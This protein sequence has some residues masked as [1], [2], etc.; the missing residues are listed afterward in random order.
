MSGPTWQHV[1]PHNL[2][3]CP[4]VER[5]DGRDYARV[6]CPDCHG[7]GVVLKHPIP[8]EHP[9]LAKGA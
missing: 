4:C 9:F 1:L 5:K 7:A 2:P 8:A 6:T 3:A